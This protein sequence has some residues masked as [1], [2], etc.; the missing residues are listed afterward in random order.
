[1]IPFSKMPGNGNDFIVICNTDEAMY[2]RRAFHARVAGVSTE[3]ICGRP[4]ESLSF[5]S[6]ARAHF[7]MRLVQCGRQRRGN[8]RK[9]LVASRD[10]AF[11][12]RH[13]SCEN[14]E[15]ETLAGVMTADSGTNRV[16]LD[17]GEISLRD[18]CASET[19]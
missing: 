7:R 18:G 3:D 12:K 14:D 15:F 17:L 16:S 11:R 13:G 2:R 10:F 8:V 5:E 9:R 19:V 4:T 1:M 6:S